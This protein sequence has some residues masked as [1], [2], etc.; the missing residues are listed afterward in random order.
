[1][2]LEGF[3]TARYYSAVRKIIGNDWGF[4]K[5]QKRPPRDPVNSLLSLGYTVL[6][7]NIYTMVRKHGL[8]PYAGLLHARR[9]R[10]PSL[11]SDL[12]EEF[13]SPVVDAVVLH[14]IT[15]GSIKGT[16]FVIDDN[17]VYACHLS[18]ETRRVFLRAI[19]TKMNSPVMHPSTG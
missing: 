8:H 11:V 10:H 4:I 16:G 14:M 18:D 1:M 6:F 12:V 19:E 17:E 9:Q 3:A 7:Y 2:G 13:R 5:R 15:G